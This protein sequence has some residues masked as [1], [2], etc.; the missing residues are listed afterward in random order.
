MEVFLALSGIGVYGNGSVY[1]G[2]C[3]LWDGVGLDV[4]G[5]GVGKRWDSTTFCESII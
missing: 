2:T 5:W 1:D 4:F 3:M